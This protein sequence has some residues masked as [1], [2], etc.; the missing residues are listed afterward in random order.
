[1]MWNRVL[2][3]GGTVLGEDVKVS[4]SIEADRQ[5]EKPAK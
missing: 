1:M 2:D 3:A 4:I 5:E